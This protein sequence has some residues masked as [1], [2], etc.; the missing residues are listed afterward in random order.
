MRRKYQEIPNIRARRTSNLS[1]SWTIE[2]IKN[3]F[4]ISS[5]F[6]RQNP[7]TIL[8]ENLAG[9]LT[10]ALFSPGYFVLVEIFR[11]IFLTWA[12]MKWYYFSISWVIL[13]PWITF[14][15]TRYKETQRQE[16]RGEWIL[17]LQSD[18]FVRPYLVLSHF[19]LVP[20]RRQQVLGR[21]YIDQIRSCRSLPSAW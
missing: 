17:M 13:M 9:K 14:S 21:N 6:H 10:K 2:F 11:D 1:R 18:S 12:F 20:H 15:Q 19:R 8:S 5:I 7:P 16:R 3:I 4:D